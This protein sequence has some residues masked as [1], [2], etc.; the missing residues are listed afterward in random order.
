MRAETVFN[1]VGNAAR[2]G[3]N[4]K[5]ARVCRLGGV[6][7]G[8]GSLDEEALRAIAADAFEVEVTTGFW[9]PSSPRQR[10]AAVADCSRRW[11]VGFDA[12]LSANGAELEVKGLCGRG[13]ETIASPEAF[14]DR[15]LRFGDG[16]ST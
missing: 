2:G 9:P 4:G 13:A 15:R 10:V 12:I 5:S 7:D 8:A 16:V 6:S 1:V 11:L 3:V 14:D